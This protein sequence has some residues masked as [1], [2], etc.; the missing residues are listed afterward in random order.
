MRVII[1]ENAADVAS[2]GAQQCIRQ[3][4]SKPE[5]V[6]GLATGSTPIALYLRLI[7]SYH[8]GEIS[9]AGV[10]TFNLDEY[11]GIDASHPQ[12]YRRF[13][14]EH[15][16]NHI[17]VDPENTHVPL[18]MSD[19]EEESR[20]YEAKIRSAGG[21]D[22]QI[23]GVGRNGHIGFNEPTSSLGSRTRVKTLAPDTIRDNSRF[24]S[25]D[26]EQPHLA[27]TMG[28]G[29]IMEARQ[30]ILLAAGESKADAVRALVEG[31]MTAM[32]PASVLQMHPEALVI[33]DKAAAGKLEL[34]EY[35]QWVQQETL[36]LQGAYC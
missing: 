27:I 31:P 1:A 6:L 3:L 32:Q 5:S 36:R 35:Y 28:I 34:V 25:Q 11:I 14:Q 7:E 4:Q 22:L 19:P 15:L 33:V 30:I 12:S 20:Q 9:F 18:G 2:Y 29:T 8:R 24:F 10:R 21:I 13:M 26:E 17:D 16:F 23:L